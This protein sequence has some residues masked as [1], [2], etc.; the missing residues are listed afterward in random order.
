MPIMRLNKI[1]RLTERSGDPG[2]FSKFQRSTILVSRS[3]KFNISVCVSLAAIM[4]RGTL[5]KNES[6]TPQKY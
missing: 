2:W 5:K 6:Q 4:K 1:T 3:L